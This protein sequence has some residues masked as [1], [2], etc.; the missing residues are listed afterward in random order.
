MKQVLRKGLGKIVV[1][2][3]PDPV[4]IPHHALV[5]PADSVISSGTATLVCPRLLESVRLGSI[6]QVSRHA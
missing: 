6:E 5:R 4:A 1:D 3:L 2:E